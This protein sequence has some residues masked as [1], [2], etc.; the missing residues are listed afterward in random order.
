VNQAVITTGYWWAGLLDREIWRLAWLYAVPAV[1]GLA[2]GMLLFSRI[3][4][5]RFRQVVFGVL[6]VSGVV[7]LV[8]G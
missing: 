5:A 8:R 4:R 7:L 3:D 1:A 2:A 6:F